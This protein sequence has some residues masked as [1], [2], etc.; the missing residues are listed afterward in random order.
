MRRYSGF[1]LVELLVVMAIIGILCSIAYPSYAAHLLRVRRLEGIIALTEAMQRQ[2]ALHTRTNRYVL[3]SAEG[4]DAA[5]AGG[6]DGFKW[7]SGAS[8]AVS[9]YELHAQACDA[10]SGTGGGDVDQCVAL[11]ASPGT[12]RVDSRFHDAACG[13]LILLSTGEQRATGTG[14]GC[15]P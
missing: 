4:G 14:K 11:V 13:S 5:A 3:F 2:E 12:D 10:D 7:W 8:P 6:A 9:A 15:W 1:T